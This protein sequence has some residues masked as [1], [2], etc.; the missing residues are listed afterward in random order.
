VHVL[1]DVQR[2]Q[3]F[4]RQ[5]TIYEMLRNDSHDGCSRFQGGV[6]QTAHETAAASSVDELHVGRSYRPSQAAGGLGVLFFGSER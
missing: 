5:L 4:M 3:L 1:D 6:R 2:R